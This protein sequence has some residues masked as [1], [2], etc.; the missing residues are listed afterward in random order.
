MKFITAAI[1]L[2]GAVNAEEGATWGYAQN[3]ADWQIAFP[4]CAK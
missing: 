1:S 2:I 3:G 4:D